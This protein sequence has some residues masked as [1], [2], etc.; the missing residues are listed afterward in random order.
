MKTDNAQQGHIV[1]ISLDHMS[2]SRASLRALTHWS[3][4]PTAPSDPHSKRTGR[5]RTFKLQEHSRVYSSTRIF[6]AQVLQNRTRT[7][8][9]IMWRVMNLTCFRRGDTGLRGYRRITVLT[10]NRFERHSHGGHVKNPLVWSCTWGV[11]FTVREPARGRTRFRGHF[12][13]I[14]W[15]SEESANIL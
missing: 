13:H 1:I 10:A 2:E 3:G 4:L 11:R 5:T 7:E 8:R 9:I 12:G 6:H 15:C 14:C